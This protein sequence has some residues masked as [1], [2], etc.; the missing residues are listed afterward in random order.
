M[1]A[2]KFGRY[3]TSDT[4]RARVKAAVK[5]SIRNLEEHGI[6]PVYVVRK[7]K[8]SDANAESVDATKVNE[9]ATRTKR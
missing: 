8:E 2:D 9:D 5:K 3:L 4:Y 1:P 7:P 6:E